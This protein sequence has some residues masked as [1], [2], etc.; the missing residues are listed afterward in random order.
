MDIDK[1]F[2]VN[3]ESRKDRKESMLNELK[4]AG[5]HKL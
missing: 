4:K 2:I 3:L 5:S 1:I